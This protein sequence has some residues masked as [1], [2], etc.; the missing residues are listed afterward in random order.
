LSEAALEQLD[1]WRVGIHVALI[2]FANAGFAIGGAASALYLV[3]DSQLK[4]H[5]TSAL[6]RRLP[7][8]AQTQM[9]ARRTIALAFPAYTAGMILGAIRAIETD[10]GGWWA[11]PRVMMSG[12]VWIVFGVYLLRVY[13]HGISSRSASWIAIVGLVAVVVLAVLA[14][15]LP[16]GF[17]VFGL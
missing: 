6:F 16:V 3:L 7:S 10:V 4:H 9:V 1:S 5:K 17:H 14:R 15:T 11:D 8:L 12:V 13:R 2:V